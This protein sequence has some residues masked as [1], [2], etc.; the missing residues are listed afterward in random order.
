LN[1]DR[2]QESGL[3]STVATVTRQ[4][5]GSYIVRTRRMSAK[6]LRDSPHSA[7]I[8]TISRRG[9]TLCSSWCMISHHLGS[10]TVPEYTYS[11]SPSCAC[12][13]STARIV[14]P[15]VLTT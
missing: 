14:V 6:K 10:L 2:Y 7:W 4:P 3:R 13:C 12:R 11:K 15:A 8:S 9:A 5:S 1:I